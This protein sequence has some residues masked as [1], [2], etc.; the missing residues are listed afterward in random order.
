MRETHTIAELRITGPAYD[1]IRRAF[2]AA[3]YDHAIR[4]DGMIDMSG[5]GVTRAQDRPFI[6]AMETTV[7]RR[8]DGTEETKV[9]YSKKVMRSQIGNTQTRFHEVGNTRTVF[10]DG[11]R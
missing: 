5:V 9:R 3:G 7:R 10:D 1:E 8:P 4:A 11:S 6:V 2:E